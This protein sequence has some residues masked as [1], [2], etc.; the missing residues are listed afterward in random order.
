MKTSGL[1]RVH[2]LTV[3]CRLNEPLTLVMI[4]PCSV[5]DKFRFAPFPYFGGKR[6]VAVPVWERLGKPTQYIEPFCGSAAM[7]LAAPEPARLEVIGDLNFYIANFWRCIKFQPEETYQWQDYPVSHVDLDARHHWLTDPERT[8]ALQVKLSDP[9]WPGDAQI[10]G[11][12][13]WGQCCWIG[14]GWCEKSQIPHAGN[15]GR[16]VQ[17]K[18]PHAGNAGRGVRDWFFFLSQRL[19]RCRVVHAD[20]SRM[21]NHHYGGDNTAIFFDPPYR[22]YERLYHKST[23]EFV[24]DDVAEWCSKNGHLRIALCGLAGDY[25]LDG[26]SEVKWSRKRLTYGG[27]KTTGDECIWFSP[28]CESQSLI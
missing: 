27:A 18:I 9:E 1:F 3:K 6:S 17:S 24:A 25:S 21:L 14:S 10:A 4:E 19:E 8:R 12:W 23:R 11:W 13:V 28:A 22:K 26:W 16:G 20:W 15:A 7:L 2:S 5:P